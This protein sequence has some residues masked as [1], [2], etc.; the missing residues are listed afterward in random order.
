[1]ALQTRS[2]QFASGSFAEAKRKVIPAAWGRALTA[3]RT[4][5]FS[6]AARPDHDSAK[7]TTRPPGPR[8]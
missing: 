2:C 1:M 6:E 5:R 3:D 7:L 4:R 8:L